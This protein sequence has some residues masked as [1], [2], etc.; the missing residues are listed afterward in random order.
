M[1]TQT[2]RVL[3]SLIRRG[4]ASTDLEALAVLRGYRL[5][6]SHQGRAAEL[7]ARPAYR[8]IPDHRRAVLLRN[9]RSLTR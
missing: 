1:K 4:Y 3:D 7:L 6:R 9:I 5:E 2:R 8:R